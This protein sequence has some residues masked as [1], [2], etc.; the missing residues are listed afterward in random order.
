MLDNQDVP[1]VDVRGVTK[2]FGSVPAVRDL[3]LCVAA[4][5]VHGLLGPRGAGKTTLLRMLFGLVRP[6]AGD[7][8]I[9][10]RTWQD[11][12]VGVLDG[13][14]GFIESPRFYPYLTGRQ[15]L[16]GLSLLGTRGGLDLEQVLDLVDLT[17]RADEKVGG[18]SAGMRRRLGVAASLLRESRLLVLDE[19]SGAVDPGG[20]RD[21]HALVGRL[22]GSGLTVLLSAH[23]LVE[24]QEICDDVTVMDHGTVVHPWCGGRESLL[25]G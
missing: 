6:D 9:F 10:G 16:E 25:A 8:A 21:L 23:D 13:V 20:V 15:H 7:I 14:A 2:T 3:S 17:G 24:V 22:A 5:E 19:P 4:G 18:Y 1:A 11:A 12:G